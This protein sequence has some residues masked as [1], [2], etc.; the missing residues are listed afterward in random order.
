MAINVNNREADAL[1][2]EFAN[3]EG[4]GISEAIVIAMREA[5]ER[6][7][8]TE[9][10][11]EIVAQLRA[12]HGISIPDRA[13]KPLAKAVFDAMWDERDVR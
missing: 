13:R 5:I 6:R 7:R 2:R 11:Q 12:K 1:T 4:I 3:M 8:K 9:A 10:Q